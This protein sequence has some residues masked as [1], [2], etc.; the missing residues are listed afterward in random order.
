M[1][2]IGDKWGTSADLQGGFSGLGGA[3]SMLYSGEGAGIQAGYERKAASTLRKSADMARAAGDI[4]AE[5]TRIKTLQANRQIAGVIGGQQADV[6]GAGFS[7]SGSAL[8]LLADSQRQGDLTKYLLEK[9]G[10]I[11]TNQFEQQAMAYEA[12]A[13]TQEGAAEA[14]DKQAESSG[15]SAAISGIA[16]LASFAMF[17]SDR[18]LK[19]DIVRIGTADNGLSIYAFR[20]TVGSIKANGAVVPLPAGMQ[21][22]FMADEVKTKHP[23]AVVRIGGYDFVNYALAVM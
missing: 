14:H 17:A 10:E 20:Y 15:I 7:A 18:R 23:R 8:D 21:I 11:D 5:S 3:V 4:S 22:G 13:T 9:Q 19:T 1:A 12:S 16:G 2:L 6:A